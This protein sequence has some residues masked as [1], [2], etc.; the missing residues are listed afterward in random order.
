M[1]SCAKT[2]IDN[3]QIFIDRAVESS[4]F[5]YVVRNTLLAESNSISRAIPCFTQ[6]YRRFRIH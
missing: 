1:W 4:T 2:S 3:V 5:M 6:K